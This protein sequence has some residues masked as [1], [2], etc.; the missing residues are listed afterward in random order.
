MHPLIT[1]TIS[2]AAIR[3]NSALL[4]A[5]TGSQTLFCP[6]VK[7]DCYGHSLDLLLETLTQES[8]WL[9]VAT[10][11]E[12]MQLRLLGY[13]GPLL[14]FFSACFA[15]DRQEALETLIAAEVT[16]TLAA[17]EEIPLLEKAARKVGK[18]ARVHLKIDSGMSRSGALP[19]QVAP[20]LNRQAETPQVQI[21][22]IYTHFATADWE[23][24]AF[25]KEQFDRFLKVLHDHGIHEQL[26]R[27]AANS[28]AIID[29]PETHLDMVR[30]GIALYGYQP[31]DAMHH[32]LTLKP[33]LRLTAPLLQVK[34][35]PAGSAC[36]YGR[37]WRAEK[38]T[39]LG[40][41][42]VGYGDGYPRCLSNLA[43]M[44]V[45]GKDAPIRGIISMDQTMIDLTAIPEAQV[46]DEVEI[47]S[48]TPD[49]P[50]SVENLARQAN[51]IP[52]EITTRLAGPRIH[53]RVAQES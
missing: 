51:T 39:R 26:L 48:D 19:E 50:N 28:A 27:H 30:P 47:V 29:L 53:K 23:D 31:S 5:Q 21:T 46:G 35:V 8:D 33:A 24:K 42:P 15:P 43:M 36:G 3:H 20:I 18:T 49:A 38:Q 11:E 2:P 34:T 44:R 25:A 10:P 22:G 1:A 45:A 7:A 37:T 40:R 12:A 9:S 32:A 41:V 16:Q 6:A 13:E 52:Y 17:E 4:K 14:T